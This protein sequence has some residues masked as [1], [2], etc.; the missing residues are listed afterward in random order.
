MRRPGEGDDVAEA[1]AAHARA[2][3]PHAAVGGADDAHE[4]EP[5]G[6]AGGLEDPRGPEDPKPYDVDFPNP[7]SALAFRHKSTS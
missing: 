3:R 2:E 5:A 4:A 7:L 6:R 1:A